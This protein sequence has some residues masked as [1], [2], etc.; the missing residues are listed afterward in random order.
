VPEHLLPLL[1]NTVFQTFSVELPGFW[2]EDVE[3]AWRMPVGYFQKTMARAMRL[4]M[5]EV[6]RCCVAKDLED[7]KAVL[8]VAP[9]G[10]RNMWILETRAI[11][12]TLSPFY[13]ML[14]E[15]RTVIFS[16]MLEELFTIRADQEN[17]YCGNDE[18]FATHPGFVDN[19]SVFLPD[20][21]PSFFDHLVWISRNN[22]NRMRRVNYYLKNVYGDPHQKR[23]FDPH[24]TPMSTLLRL[25]KVDVFGTPVAQCLIRLKWEAFGEWMYIEGVL[26]YIAVFFLFMMGQVF[27]RHPYTHLPFTEEIEVFCQVCMALQFAI[28]LFLFAGAQ[29]PTIYREWNSDQTTTVD[30]ICL[31]IPVPNFF[32]RFSDVTRFVLNIGMIIG[33]ITDEHMVKEFG[34]WL[35]DYDVTREVHSWGISVAVILFT[36]QLFDLFALGTRTM[37][38]KLTTESILTEVIPFLGVLCIMYTAF[39]AALSVNSIMIPAADQ[40]ELGKLDWLLINIEQMS[41]FGKAFETLFAASISCLQM[42][43]IELNLDSKIMMSLYIFIVIFLI[44][45]MITGSVSAMC[46]N[47]SSDAERL[48]FK[49]QAADVIELESS[50]PIDE[51]LT[52]YDSFEFNKRV[53]FD[54]GDLGLPGCIQIVESVT[55]HRWS[56]EKLDRIFR[57]AGDTNPKLPWPEDETTADDDP[58]RKLKALIDDLTVR[59]SKTHGI[60]KSVTKK[61]KAWKTGDRGDGEKGTTT[62]TD[63]DTGDDSSDNGRKA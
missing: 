20:L 30:L 12:S 36:S 8:R 17:Y 22:E 51:R 13:W 19:L 34:D 11:G 28:N 35:V 14:H 9:R 45:T 44:I 42:E 43:Y 16:Y 63:D 23:F 7:L 55:A 5:N 26:P 27:T 53:E 49:R 33:F 57:F 62:I 2:N 37:R 54:V 31:Q 60:M 39:G 3:G 58:T 52:L 4:G 15:N 24:N 48:C 38:F 18:L 29:L 47:I 59:L 41:D 46:H 50:I 10:E 40:Y 6:C 21:F 32:T 56:L 61:A 1:A 25:A